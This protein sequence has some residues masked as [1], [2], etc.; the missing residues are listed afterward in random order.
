[1][2]RDE[3]H[4]ARTCAACK[5]CC[6]RARRSGA[7]ASARPRLTR[8]AARR[9]RADVLRELELSTLHG[10]LWPAL[11]ARGG[12]AD[13]PGAGG[14]HGAHPLGHRA[15]APAD[16][17]HCRTP[18]SRP[19]PGRGG[20]TRP[21][22][23]A[24]GSGM[25][26]V[27][28]TPHLGTG[29]ARHRRPVRLDRWLQGHGGS[30]LPLVDEETWR[31]SIRPRY[32]PAPPPPPSALITADDWNPGDD[33][34]LRER[35]EAR[36]RLVERLITAGS[37]AG[38]GALE[39]FEELRLLARSSGSHAIAP[40]SDDL[41]LRIHAPGAGMASRAILRGPDFDLEADNYRFTATTAARQPPRGL[42]SPASR[43][44]G[45][46]ASDRRRCHG[47]ARW[48][49]RRSVAGRRHRESHAPT[50]RAASRGESPCHTPA[51]RARHAR[52][53]PRGT[54]T[55]P[56]C[57]ALPRAGR[58]PASRSRALNA[59]QHTPGASGA[60]QPAWV[61]E[62]L[63]THNLV[64]CPPAPLSHGERGWGPPLGAGGPSGGW[65]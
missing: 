56:R 23:P 26:R 50:G 7:S 44:A 53:A 47:A 49:R 43:R 17:G 8:R 42:A 46:A 32:R 14:P 9:R 1:M 57:R 12:P 45:R 28:S 20:A 16:P 21:S 6:A 29:A 59:R 48:R 24:S 33:P 4:G 31:R 2:L 38:L 30:P 5:G 36:S 62:P 19:R 61:A 18:A 54:R 3:R 11:L 13:Q 40:R 60:C 52:R 64:A 63:A 25:P 55:H 10:G 27:R 34:R 22:A 15:P 37:V 58:I 35:E 51:R 41:G 39:N 65:G